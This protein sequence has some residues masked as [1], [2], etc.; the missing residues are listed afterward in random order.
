MPDY[1][2]R[3]NVVC[4][5]FINTFQNCTKLQIKATIFY[6]DGEQSTRFL[7]QSVN[8]TN[9]FNRS[10][11]SGTQGTAPDLWNCNFGTGTPTKTGA[12]GGAGNNSTSISNY[13]SIPSQWK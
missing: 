2:F 12:F 1:L 11:F 5:S 4:T 13:T 10:S 9:C 7:N 8:F 3:Y 6:A